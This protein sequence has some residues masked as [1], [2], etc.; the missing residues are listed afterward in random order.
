MDEQG[1]PVQFLAGKPCPFFSEIVLTNSPTE[2]ADNAVLL[3]P[4]SVS[5]QP[6]GEDEGGVLLK[7]DTGDMFSLNDTAVA[8]LSRL[9]GKRKV[10][11]IIKEMLDEFEVDAATLRTDI[12]ELAAELKSAGISLES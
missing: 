9:D 11:A 12:S 5:I 6:L 2:L 3:L 7:M 4:A 10:G 8:F 1:P